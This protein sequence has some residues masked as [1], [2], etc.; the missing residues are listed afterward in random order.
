MEEA[1][2]TKISDWEYSF[3]NCQAREKKIQEKER[4]KWKSLRIN[5]KT[6]FSHALFSFFIA[7]C[8][9]SN[10]PST[11]TSKMTN[12]QTNNTSIRF[13]REIHKKEKRPRV[14]NSRKR[15]PNRRNRIPQK[16]RERE[17]ERFVYLR[18]MKYLGMGFFFSSSENSSSF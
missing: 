10:G 2:S 4:E 12:R 6:F 3:L 18:E 9:K 11:K 16:R 1:S 14:S 7:N 15:K 13:E 8:Q 5:S 17:R